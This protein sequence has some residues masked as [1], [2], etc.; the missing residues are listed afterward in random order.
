MGIWVRLPQ[1][2]NKT[3]ECPPKVKYPILL[4]KYSAFTKLIVQECH[5]DCK[6]LGIAATLY[7]LRL[8]GY[9]GKLFSLVCLVNYNRFWVWLSD[10]IGFL[11]PPNNSLASSVSVKTAKELM[12]EGRKET[13]I[14]SKIL[15]LF[16]W[17]TVLWVKKIFL[18]LMEMVASPRQ[19]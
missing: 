7:K 17:S 14:P 18:N 11:L 10:S 5:N 15:T 9:W 16:L 13:K 8:S 1:Q 3:I 2:I 19:C 12:N 6:H 4:P